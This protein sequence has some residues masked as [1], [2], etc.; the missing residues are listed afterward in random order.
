MDEDDSDIEATQRETQEIQRR[1]RN[2]QEN[3]HVGS[4]SMLGL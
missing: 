3:G 2:R 4:L 1:V